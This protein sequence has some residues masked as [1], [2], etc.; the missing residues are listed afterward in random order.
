MLEFCSCSE[1]VYDTAAPKMD[2]N[3]IS[4][5]VM[6]LSQLWAHAQYNRNFQDQNGQVRSS[7][8]AVF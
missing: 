8:H 7:I 3:N 4:T 2:A 6:S 1:Q 5:N